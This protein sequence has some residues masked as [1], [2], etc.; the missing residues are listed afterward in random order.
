MCRGRSVKQG[1]T[2]PTSFALV[3]MK[4]R[5]WSI[6]GKFTLSLVGPSLQDPRTWGASHT[7]GWA[8]VKFAHVNN[9]KLLLLVLPCLHEHSCCPDPSCPRTPSSYSAVTYPL[10]ERMFDCSN[11]CS[12]ALGCARIRSK[13]RTCRPSTRSRKPGYHMRVTSQ[14]VREDMFRLPCRSD[15]RCPLERMFDQK[16]RVS[17]RT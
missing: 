4:E 6:A 12:N 1:Q 10:F 5:W 16:T 13:R 17:L 9:A 3:Y 11:V 7:H 15:R 14:N 8:H 2:P